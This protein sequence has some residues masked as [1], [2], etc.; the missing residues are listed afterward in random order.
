MDAKGLKQHAIVIRCQAPAGRRKVPLHFD[1]WVI[2]QDAG[3]ADNVFANC[4]LVQDR[5]QGRD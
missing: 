1:G 2:H 3:A 5:F 4:Q